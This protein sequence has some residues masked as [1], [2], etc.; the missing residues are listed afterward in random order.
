MPIPQKKLDKIDPL[1]GVLHNVSKANTFPVMLYTLSHE[2]VSLDRLFE[3]AEEQGI[4]G[5][6]L[7]FFVALSLV[8][9]ENMG[10]STPWVMVLHNFLKKEGLDDLYKEF[11]ANFI[12]KN[13]IS[14][15]EEDFNFKVATADIRREFTLGISQGK[16]RWGEALHVQR[17]QDVEA[18]FGRLFA[19]GQ[20]DIIRKIL[21]HEELSKTERET[22]SRVVKK[23]LVAIIDPE[24]Q[25]VAR[26][27]TG[28]GWKNRKKNLDKN[29]DLQLV[30]SRD[31]S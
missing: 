30:H 21:H 2:S 15:K 27:L 7:L 14:F 11:Y 12:K 20:C 9:F 25:R 13:H 19:P 26:V 8:L 6:R 22:F 24:L 29:K 10:V 28:S 23:K 3:E 18:L 17:D 16:A 1:L 4:G 31:N 5:K